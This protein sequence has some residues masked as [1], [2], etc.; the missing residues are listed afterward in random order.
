MSVWR[1]SEL[2]PYPVESSIY[3]LFIVSLNGGV[4]IQELGKPRQCIYLE[5]LTVCG[6]SSFVHI[7]HTLADT[8]QYQQAC[9]SKLPSEVLKMLSYCLFLSFSF[10]KEKT[11]ATK[12]SYLHPC[13]WKKYLQEKDSTGSFVLNINA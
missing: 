2:F 3:L 13:T 6:C 8:V 4:N 7:S 11:L 12:L 5:K 1:I 10:F 9:G